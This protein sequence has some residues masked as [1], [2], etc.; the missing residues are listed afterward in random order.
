[1]RPLLWVSKSHAK[2]AAALREIGHM[3]NPFRLNQ[4]LCY[5]ILFLTHNRI[6]KILQLFGITS[7]GDAHCAFA[8]KARLSSPVQPQDKTTEGARHPHRNP[9]FEHIN[10]KV[11]AFQNGGLPRLS[12]TLQPCFVAPSLRLTVMRLS[13]RGSIIEK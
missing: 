2:P 9:Q 1:M 6:Q 3:R 10:A 5:N 8:Q 4:G 12:S 11:L 13:R 7:I